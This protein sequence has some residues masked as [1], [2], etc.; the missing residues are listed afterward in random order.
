MIAILLLVASKE[1]FIALMGGPSMV[2]GSSGMTAQQLADRMEQ[3]LDSLTRPG[4]RVYP[5]IGNRT[6]FWDTI[7]EEL[8]EQQ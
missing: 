4:Y 1:D 5:A 2:M 8:D 7:M 6:R 3:A